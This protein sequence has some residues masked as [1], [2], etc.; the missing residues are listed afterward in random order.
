MF[1]SNIGIHIL[2]SEELMRST[3]MKKLEPS[4]VGKAMNQRKQRQKA[5]SK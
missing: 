2:C 3:Q 5:E 4:L 1:T